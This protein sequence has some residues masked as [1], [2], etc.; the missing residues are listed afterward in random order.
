MGM[1][2]ILDARIV[3][4]AAPRGAGPGPRRGAAMR[5]LSVI[6][7]G[8]VQMLDGVVAA[9]APGRPASTAGEVINADGRVCMPALVDCHTHLCFAGERWSEWERL[10]AGESYES[11]LAA[12]GGIMS[13]VRATRGADVASLAQDLGA[14]L[15]AA[16]RLGV[17]TVEVKSGY[18]LDW[19]SELKM[20]EAIALAA[21]GTTQLIVPTCLGGHAIPPDA[22]AWPEEFAARVAEL[23]QRHPG[24]AVDA[25]CERGAL[26][27]AQCRAILDAARR[28]GLP[29]R[30]HTDQFHAI[31]G[32]ALAVEMDADTVDHLE[33]ADDAAIETVARSRAVAVLLPCSAYA[34]GGPFAPGHRLVERGAAVAVASNA[35]PGSAPTADLRFA[36][37]LAVRHAGLTTA[38]ALTAVT[39]NAAC[40]LRLESKVGS[41]EPGKRG[42][43]IVLEERDERALA[44]GFGGPPPR[45]VV[46]AGRLAVAP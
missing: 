29:R 33:S 4:M 39:W 6:E 38:E 2:T 21:A 34:L 22:P 12:G 26:S 31:G 9:V 20:L 3:T 46:L 13:T 23:A 30:L 25:F 24:V 1:L 18:G 44:H 37:H 7:R 14:R 41:L 35:N 27:V 11:I 17:G 28:H 5:E 36:V 8:F 10:R 42:D 16:A 15:R 32:A 19:S 45:H 40:A 43:A